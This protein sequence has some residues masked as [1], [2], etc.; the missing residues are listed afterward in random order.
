MTG[1][2]GKHA[3]FV[4]HAEGVAQD[5]APP[6]LATEKQVFRNVQGW[7]DCQV[8]VDGFDALPLRIAEVG[9]AEAKGKTQQQ[10]EAGQSTGQGL[11]RSG[12]ERGV[13]L[14][15]NRERCRG[16][17]QAMVRLPSIRVMQDAFARKD[18]AFD[19]TFFAAVK[20]QYFDVDATSSIRSP[21]VGAGVA[22]L[23]AILSTRI[24]LG[25]GAWMERVKR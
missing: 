3:L 14:L 9:M 25:W 17:D 13:D 2:L 7:C 23:A 15:P 4:E 12:G 5:V 21:R 11:Q 18:P 24:G 19:G 8:L 16:Y 6:Q 22:V 10:S 1:C 20:N